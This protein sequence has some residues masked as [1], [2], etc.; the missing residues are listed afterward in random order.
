MNSARIA[1]SLIL[2]NPQLS[3]LSVEREDIVEGHAQVLWHDPSLSHCKCFL[4]FFIVFLL[5][6]RIMFDC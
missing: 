1:I 6:S 2:T 3:A 5:L 4:L